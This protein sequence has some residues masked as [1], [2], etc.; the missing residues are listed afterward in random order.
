MKGI[1]FA[2]EFVSLFC[3]LFFGIV[4]I[5]SIYSYP[6]FTLS[7]LLGMILSMATQITIKRIR[8]EEQ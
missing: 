5:N 6:E 3:F 1:L 8:E 2:L 4:F 7:A